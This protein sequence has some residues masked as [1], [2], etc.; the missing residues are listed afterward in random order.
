MSKTRKKNKGKRHKN[1]PKNGIPSRGGWFSGSSRRNRNWGR[2]T[3]YD[4]ISRLQC[5]TLVRITKGER[6]ICEDHLKFHQNGVKTRAIMHHYQDVD[7]DSI[8][9]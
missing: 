3:H 7:C 2:C 6:P 5:T 9:F 1:L 8:D 4:R